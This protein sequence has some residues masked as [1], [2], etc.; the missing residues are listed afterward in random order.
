MNAADL[1]LWASVPATIL[2][3][4]AGLLTL[5][6]AI[7]LV[8]LPDFFARLHCPSM[9]STLGTGCVLLSSVL[10]S[11]ALAARPVIHELLIALFMV[12]TQP[13]SAMLLIRAAEYRTSVNEKRR[14]NP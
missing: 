12:M 4:L 6:G 1:P 11:S 5:I 10:V 3:V 7:G 2:L 8:R 9:G 13:V 14:Q